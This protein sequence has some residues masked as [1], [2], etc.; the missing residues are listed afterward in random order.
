MFLAD[1]NIF[2]EIL[3]EQEKISDCK[4]FL[5]NNYSK[6][7][8]SD[9]SLHS[10]GVILY[11]YNKQEIF[12]DFIQDVLPTIKLVNLPQEAYNIFSETGE[13]PDLD[14]DD[15]YQYSIAKYFDLEIATM[16]SDFRKVKDV[17]IFFI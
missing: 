10:I 16:D 2:L 11:R 13:I 1:T 3:L 7:Y 17:K 12:R 6:I 4:K 9:F 8:L 5:E 15:F 14:F